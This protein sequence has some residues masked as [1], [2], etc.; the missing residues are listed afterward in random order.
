MR[1]DIT[2]NYHFCVD[3]KISPGVGQ[4]LMINHVIIRQKYLTIKVF[5]RQISIKA[6]YITEKNH[7]SA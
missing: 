5:T 4:I 2:Q 7:C 3:L 6:T 1:L